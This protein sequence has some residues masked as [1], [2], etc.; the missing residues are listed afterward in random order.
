MWKEVVRPTKKPRSVGPNKLKPEKTAS[1]KK[2][3]K[4]NKKFRSVNI[5]IPEKPRSVKIQMP[6]HKYQLVGRKL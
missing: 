5:Q 2:T 6:E 3:R 1:K 4:K